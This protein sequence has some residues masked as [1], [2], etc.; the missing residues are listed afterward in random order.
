[1]ALT[2]YGLLVS[3]FLDTVSSALQVIVVLIGPL[4]A[5]YATDIV[6]RRVRYDG[7]A[8]SDETPGSPFWYTGGVNPAGALALV[9]GVTSAALCVNTL[10]TGPIATAVGGVDL[11]LPVGM[12]VSATLYAL[13]MRNDSAVRA[14]RAEA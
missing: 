12:T 7:L 3:N 10:Y 4:M 13:L 11:S 5:V 6:L 14:A 8:L 2:L 1:M 9:A